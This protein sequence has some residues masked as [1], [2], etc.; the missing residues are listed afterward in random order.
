MAKKIII[1]VGS[2]SGTAAMVADEVSDVLQ[3][4]DLNPEVKAMN[5]VNASIFEEN[6]LVLICTSTTGK[7]EVPDNAK[8]LYA[9]LQ[10]KRPDLSGV[11]YGIVGFGSSHYSATYCRGPRSFDELMQDLGAQKIGDSCEHDAQSGIYAEEPAL[12]WIESWVELI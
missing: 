7:G 5:E 9:E 2:V 12:D 4:S 3:E 1:L 11:K 10:S 6:K 8:E